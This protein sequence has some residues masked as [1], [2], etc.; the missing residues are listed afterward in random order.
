MCSQNP[1]AAACKLAHIGCTG[2]SSQIEFH[3]HCPS[4]L[5]VDHTTMYEVLMKLTSCNDASSLLH[6]FTIMHA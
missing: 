2:D 1:E 5:P 3:P 6:G 4:I